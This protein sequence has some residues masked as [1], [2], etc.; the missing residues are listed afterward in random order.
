MNIKNLLLA[1]CLFTFILSSC[2]KDDPITSGS[3]EPVM[4]DCAT[5]FDS[6]DY[7]S[8]CFVGSEDM[9]VDVKEGTGTTCIIELGLQPG[10]V[11]DYVTLA[12]FET[13][14]VTSVP[15]LPS[16]SESVFLSI[17]NDAENANTISNLGNDA[18]TSEDG[19]ATYV[20]KELVVR[21]SN[22]ILTFDTSYAK[23]YGPHCANDFDELIKLA[24]IVLGE[25]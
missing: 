15:G 8:I 9:L 3:D 13:A 24:K 14:V 11:N 2:G 7:S 23:E 6:G 10:T 17:K 18:F 4:Y 20:D 25:L 16:I 22:L 21:Y 1:T 19:D 5:L 12:I